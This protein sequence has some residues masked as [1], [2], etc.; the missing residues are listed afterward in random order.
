MRCYICDY[1]KVLPSEYNQETGALKERRMIWEPEERHW[2][3]S[4]CNAEGRT[5]A[6]ELHQEDEIDN[7]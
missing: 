2:V 6:N 3:C 5:A 1:S 4:E 7:E